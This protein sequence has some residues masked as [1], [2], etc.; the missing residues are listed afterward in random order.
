MQ[1]F[2]NAARRGRH[3]E[4]LELLERESNVAI[5]HVV[6]VVVQCD[7]LRGAVARSRGR[8]RSVCARV[9]KRHRR[10]R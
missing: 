2:T 1:N 8:D 10:R 7:R 3:N 4:L 5:E 9:L 6:F